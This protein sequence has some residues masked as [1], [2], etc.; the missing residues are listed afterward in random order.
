VA[1]FARRSLQRMLSSI[2]EQQRDL[3]L[4]K[5]VDG[6]NRPTFEALGFEWEL[7]IIHILLATGSVRNEANLG[8]TSR[9]DIFYEARGGDGLR[10]VADVATPSDAARDREN[11]VNRLWDLLGRR[12]RKL[13]LDGGFDIRVEGRLQGPHRDAKMALA[14]P[15]AKH[16]DRFFEERVTPWLKGIRARK[17]DREAMMIAEGDVEFILT[18]DANARFWTGG[19]PSYEAAYSLRR[20]S[21]YSALKEKAD[22][23]RNSGFDGPM[24]I[25]LCDGNCS[26]CGRDQAG[27]QLST[28]RRF[29]RPLFKA[30]TARSASLPLLL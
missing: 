12:S 5:I 6:L 14:L 30:T 18:Y 19:H 26:S 29:L 16:I 21:V 22:Q 20:N 2:A 15:A 4:R 1:I 13:R 23:L 25:F 28:S 9:P 27:Q 10:F 24:G 7:V 3:P 8:G 11:P 17:P